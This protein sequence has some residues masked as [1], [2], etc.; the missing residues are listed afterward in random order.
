LGAKY[1]LGGKICVFNICLKQIFLKKKTILGHKK[2]FG[3]TGPEFPFVATGQGVEPVQLSQIAQNREVFR[4]L[5]G[6]CPSDLPRETAGMKIN[7]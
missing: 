5:L 3:R 2:Y 4:V 7:E 1:I 6:W